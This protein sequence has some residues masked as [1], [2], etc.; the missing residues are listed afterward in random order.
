MLV[1]VEYPATSLRFAV[2]FEPLISASVAYDVYVGWVGGG[3][4]CD[5]AEHE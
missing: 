1:P 2:M 3:N 4:E 5:R